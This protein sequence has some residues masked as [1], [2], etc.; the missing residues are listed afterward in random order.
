MTTPRWSWRRAPPL[1]WAPPPMCAKSN[2][3]LTGVKEARDVAKAAEDSLMGA[4]PP[5]GEAL[6]NYS[7]EQLQEE[8][9]MCYTRDTRVG[10][11]AA[12]GGDGKGVAGVTWLGQISC[13]RRRTTH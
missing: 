6:V 13:L 11:P 9:L 12:R 7:P 10:H 3:L 5:C 2:L 4:N 1:Q 8:E